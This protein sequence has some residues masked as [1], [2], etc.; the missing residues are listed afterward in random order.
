MTIEAQS[1]DGKVHEF[2]DETPRD[3]IDRAMKK[4]AEQN[5]QKGMLREGAE[6]LGIGLAG[7]TAGLAGG[8]FGDVQG[9]G[10]GEEFVR[11]LTGAPAEMPRR[12]ETSQQGMTDKG[13]LQGGGLA[14]GLV[15]QAF[16]HGPMGAA[17]TTSEIMGEVEK[18]TGPLPSPQSVFGEYMRTIGSFLPLTFTQGLG[19]QGWVTRIGDRI[20]NT[21]FPAVTSETAGQFGRKISK[22]PAVEQ[23]FRLV[24][25]MTPTTLTMA[26]RY[27]PDR[28]LQ[29]VEQLDEA[30]TRGYNHPSV[31]GLRF[32]VGIWSQA[33]QRIANNLAGEGAQ[34]V[35][36]SGGGTPSAGGTGQALQT[37]IQGPVRIDPLG[38]GARVPKNE[39][40]IADIQ[41]VREQLRGVM[42]GRDVTDAGWAS[43]ALS[44]IDDWL[45]RGAQQ[46][47]LLAGDL[48][49]A[50]PQL[51]NA[52]G[53]YWAARTL[54]RIGDQIYAAELRSERSRF[55]P[56]FQER[57]QNSVTRILENDNL[58]RRYTP[59]EQ[60]MLR[61]I[62]AGR[63]PDFLAGWAKEMSP[64]HSVQGML[65][66]GLAGGGAHLAGRSGLAVGAGLAAMG[67]VAELLQKA[68]ITKLVRDLQGEIVSRAP[69]A[70]Q[71]GYS[72]PALDLPN[73]VA[74]GV[75]AT[76]SN[77]PVAGR[78]Q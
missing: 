72:L 37:M 38:G 23:G 13:F 52:N 28:A 65:G 70:R 32:R 56:N 69:Y 6:Q 63:W 54:D 62:N 18:L 7:G 58:L 68:F 14:G 61:Q 48:A 1:A 2:P 51:E 43:R 73:P 31:R 19:A 16:G 11:G 77:V 15:A 75:A 78:Y 12:G 5:P 35:N 49:Q 44:Q 59:S 74:P 71:T 34:L 57:I 27:R 22:E 20:K 29:S 9:P 4:Y 33:G 26:L 25:G 60:Q 24:G 21:L 42:A 8:M 17:P 46:G 64:R 3:V 36:P 55:G 47:D 53:N 10:R 67:E 41:A 50:R 39:V 45:Q 30:A 40:T 66:F 76:L